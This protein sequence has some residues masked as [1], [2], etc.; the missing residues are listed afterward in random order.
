MSRSIYALPD[1]LHRDNGFTVQVISVLA[2][3]FNGDGKVDGE[4]LLLWQRDPSVG[5]LAIWEADYDT[6]ASLITAAL[7]AVPEPSTSIVLLLGMVAMLL[8]RD[9]VVS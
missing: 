1:S 6:V 8:R 2:G 3:N 5:S 4:D 9:V 7:T